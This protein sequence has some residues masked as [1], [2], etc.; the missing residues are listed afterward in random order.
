MIDAV[1]NEI[2]STTLSLGPGGSGNL[3]HDLSF[4]FPEYPVA[5]LEDTACY[6]YAEKYIHRFG[7]RTLLLSI[8][9]EAS[10]PLYL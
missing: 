5:L 2:Y 4:A 8:S 6:A 7:K 9:E 1:R 10:V 3:I